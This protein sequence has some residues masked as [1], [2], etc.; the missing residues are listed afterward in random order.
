MFVYTGNTSYGKTITD[1]S[2]FRNILYTSDE[3][4]LADFIN[5]PTYRSSSKLGDTDIS[6]VELARARIHW[7]LPNQIA[8]AVYQ[9]SKLQILSFMYDCL[10]YYVDRNKYDLIQSDTDSLYLSISASSLEEVVK[11]ERKREFFENYNSWFPTVA[12]EKHYAEFVETKVEG[13]EWVKPPCCIKLNALEQRKPGL[14]KKEYEGDGMICLCS[15]TYFCWSQENERQNKCASKGLSKSNNI[16]T[17]EDYLSV[18]ETETSKSGKNRSFKTLNNRIVTYEQTRSS[19][20]YMYIK[21]PVKA[22]GIST[23]PLLL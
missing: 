1:V 3:D 23:G 17:K 14:F 5:Q 10:D 19:L 7:N 9:L 13:R 11:P 16:L 12:C 22:D 18:L 20:S 15:K 21:R 8:Y 2:R 6:E 4:E